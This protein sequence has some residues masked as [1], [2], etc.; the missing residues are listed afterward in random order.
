M[1]ESEKTFQKRQV[2]LKARIAD[3][4]SGEYVKEEGLAPNYVA[5]SNGKHAS[6][7]NILGVIVLKSGDSDANNNSIILDDGSGKIS[8]R[9]FN[10]NKMLNTINVGDIALMI[11]KPRQFGDEKYIIPEIVKKIDNPLWVELRNL[12]LGKVNNDTQSKSLMV[13]DSEICNDKSSD[14]GT[15][16]TVFNL[17]REFDLGNGADI[18]EIIKRAKANN[19]EN[20]EAIMENLLKNGEVFELRPGKVK[21]L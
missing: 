9:S 15:I 5:L 7:V 11:G 6:R 12:E 3:I 1:S 20:A 17:I 2:A 13:E 4:L 16:S 21:V 10:D 18:E 8:V 14:V 19:I